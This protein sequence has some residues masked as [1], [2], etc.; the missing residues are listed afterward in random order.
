MRKGFPGQTWKVALA[1]VSVTA[2][3]MAL[4]VQLFERR[5]ELEEDRLAAARLEEALAESRARLKKELLAELR[6]EVVQKTD[7]TEGR[8]LPNAV[9]R[10]GEAGASSTLQQVLASE[11]S[12]EAL[13]RV[14]V[15]LDVLARQMEESG[16]A[17]RR[18]L[19][20]L[21]A[22]VRRELEASRKVRSLL[23]AAVIPLVAQLL[24]SLA[25][26]RRGRPDESGDEH[27]KT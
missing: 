27:D 13:T 23:L 20:E 19:E 11:G 1:A 4:Y 24:F 9:L 17:Q 2:L 16:R 26:P 14:A 10:R 5:L 22:E 18:D 12:Q 8:P 3:A 7:E 21:R 25:R 15:S 6:A